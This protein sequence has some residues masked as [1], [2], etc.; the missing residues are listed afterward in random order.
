MGLP[1]R[2]ADIDARDDRGWTAF[3]PDGAM[4]LTGSD[5]GVIRLW[6]VAIGV[7]EY[8]IVPL[9]DSW[10]VCL[11][12][13]KTIRSGP[14][15]WRYAYSLIPSDNGIPRVTAPREEDLL[16]LQVNQSE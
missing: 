1:D 12:D 11:S 13:G 10:V 2:G 15:L 16:R 3:A 14:N 4:L 9:P 5:D 6:N 7:L 8:E